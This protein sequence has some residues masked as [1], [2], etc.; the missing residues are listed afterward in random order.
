[1]RRKRTEHEFEFNLPIFP[2]D[3]G[4]DDFKATMNGKPL[5]GIRSLAVRAGDNGMTNVVIDFEA[6]VAVKAVAILFAD[7]EKAKDVDDEV[8]LATLF[9]DAMEEVCNT[10]QE[11]PQ[12]V[13]KDYSLKADLVKRL[14]SL[15]LEQLK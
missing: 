13:L 1:M 2:Y 4:A 8:V 3:K 11:E 12:A 7:I 14:I 10:N 15:S 5:D 9:D 6:A